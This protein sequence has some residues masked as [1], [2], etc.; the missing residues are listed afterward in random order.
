[1]GTARWSLAEASDGMGPLCN[2][3]EQS[4]GM[5]PLCNTKEQCSITNICADAHVRQVPAGAEAAQAMSCQTS[6]PLLK[7][8]EKCAEEEVGNPFEPGL[9]DDDNPFTPDRP[10]HGAS[11][12]QEGANP[13]SED[14]EE[15]F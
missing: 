6:A 1:M 12:S 9:S 15:C 11:G 13:F 7:P 3:K 4:D 8:L 2:T 10:S 14:E 5:G